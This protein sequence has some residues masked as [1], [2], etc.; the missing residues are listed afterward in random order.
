MIDPKN[1]TTIKKYSFLLK[2]SEDEFRD[3]VV[4]PVFFRMK[5][6][7]GRDL[8]GKEEYGKDALFVGVNNLRH[9]EL[10]YVQ[11]KKG[12]LNMSSA[13]SENVITAITQLRTSLATSY[14]FLPTKK[15]INPSHVVL[16][17]SGTINDKARNHIVEEV[18]DPR[19]KFYDRDDLIPLIDE[20]YGE[21]WLGI[22]S[23]KLP[24][25]RN[26]KRL[27]EQFNENSFLSDLVAVDA[28][29]TAVTKE[30]YVSLK[31]SFTEE[32]TKRFKGKVT[33]EPKITEIPAEAVLK[34]KE[35]KILILG[36]PGSGK[37][38]ILKRIA[39]I[40]C[41]Q[42]LEE[43][44]SLT[45][46]VLLRAINLADQNVDLLVS[47]NQEM[48]KISLS[49]KSCFSAD[50]LLKGN[51]AVL[52]DAL[53][54][55]AD[56]SK[57]KDI[58][59]KIQE[60]SEKYPQ[61]K[62]ILTS[63]KYTFLKNLTDLEKYAEYR[64]ENINL[65]QA[66]QI[67]EKLS[68]KKSLP[69]IILQE[70]IRRLQ[71]IHGVTLSPLLVAVFIATS[72]YSRKDIPANITELFKK[73]TEMMLGRWDSNKGLNQQFHAN[74]KD[75]L[76]RRLAFEMHKKGKVVINEKDCI[77]FFTNELKIRGQREADIETLIYETLHRSG[78]FR[79]NEGKIEFRHLLL[80]EFFA[81][82]GIL[83]SS[84]IVALIKEQWWQHA[85]IFYFGENPG[86]SSTLEETIKD[87]VTNNANERFL[88][89]VTFGLAVQACYLIRV[90]QKYD[91]L[92]WVILSLANIKDDLLKEI[93]NR[94]HKYPLTLFILY[95]LFGKDSVAFEILDRCPP[96]FLSNIIQRCKDENS[97][98]T[99]Q[100]WFIVGLIECGYLENAYEQLKDFKPKDNRL[101][102][103]LHLGC[104]LIENVKMV[105]KEH[106]KIAE[107]I[108]K[109]I[110]PKIEFLRLQI[111]DEY[112]SELLEVRKGKVEVIAK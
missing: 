35:N 72:E 16:C 70:T 22:D 27:L 32:V 96:A 48:Q 83:N 8:C 7:D 17:A 77:K 47:C 12:N 42:P 1:I 67:I 111:L 62:I 39:Y 36:E 57:I 64:V 91:F 89:T 101:Y 3:K 56:L 86:D 51:L 79:C 103:A 45:L 60:F 73:F 19:I 84:E 95:Y 40:L 71:D 38:T 65:Q 66:T 31:L 24:Y 50:D 13:A 107:K 9:E 59:R 34:R 69:K 21:L 87:L 15:K 30:L 41:E 58:L 106:R 82:R 80:Q 18:A 6:K 63:R 76:L 23:D 20:L 46:P 109:Q 78:L 110:S 112:K 4:R 93:L 49:Q 68:K 100:F 99:A 5:L 11:T 105:D 26:L 61:C 37:S 25:L 85:I 94:G 92:S 74:L 55:I 97:K 10:Y 52:I 90:A 104:C 29:S 88:A 44:T 28:K 53:D 2:M 98:D 75:F 81:G 14:V 108:R 54:E 102:L 33:R 43:R